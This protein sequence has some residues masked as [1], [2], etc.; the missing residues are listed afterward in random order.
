MKNILITICGRG[1]SKGIPGKNIRLINGK[2]L[3][4]W[5]IST[6]KKF[7][8]RHNTT[9]GLST[10]SQDILDTAASYGLTTSYRRPDEMATDMAGKLPVIRDLMEFHEKQNRT[11][12][13]FVID[14]D[15]TSPLRTAEDLSNALQMLEDNS[16]AVNLF[17]VSKA[18][19]NPYFNMVEQQPD[20]YYFLVKQGSFTTR[21]S[22]PKVYDLN[23]SFYIFRRSY[24]DEYNTAITPRS[25]IYEVP[26]LCFDLD[27]P[28]DFEFMEYLMKENKT[29]I[30]L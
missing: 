3:I 19:R 27:E 11:K 21:Q 5:T 8:E 16:K 15:I 1:G 24:F 29:G 4:A 6:A 25:I 13:D 14:L 23:A 7:A 17:S 18:H 9:I 30:E 2:P 28:I 12:F 10:D 26:H 22:A 20:G